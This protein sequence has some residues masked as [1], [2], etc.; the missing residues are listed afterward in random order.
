MGSIIS[1][2]SKQML[3]WKGYDPAK[4]TGLCDD[5]IFIACKAFLDGVLVPYRPEGSVLC[6]GVENIFTTPNLDVIFIGPQAIEI[7]Q[8]PCKKLGKSKPKKYVSLLHPVMRSQEFRE[9]AKSQDVKQ[10]FLQVLMP[11]HTCFLMFDAEGSRMVD[12]KIRS[13]GWDPDI[14]THI[15]R[16]IPWDAIGP[17]TRKQELDLYTYSFDAPVDKFC[18][19]ITMTCLKELIQDPDWDKISCQLG[20]V[21]VLRDPLAKSLLVKK[22]KNSRTQDYY[23][24][25]I[26][27]CFFELINANVITRF[28]FTP[29]Q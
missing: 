14:L 2:V 1:R 27:N 19:G 29:K 13:F 28:H 18:A 15:R 10:I 12:N 7:R 17:N 24:K 4:F 20:I 22:M 9:L 25:T 23:C 16:V 5:D 11:G 3:S 6:G 26:M 21:S 8:V